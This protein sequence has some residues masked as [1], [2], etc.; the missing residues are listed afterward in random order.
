MAHPSDLEIRDGAV[1]VR[2]APDR[3][4]TY[5]QVIAKFYGGPGTVLGKGVVNLAAILGMVK[6][7]DDRHFYIEQ[8][9]YPGTPLDSVKRDYLYLSALRF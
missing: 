6:S 5:G 9:T 3:R 1:A 8:E 4:L 2:G 7:L